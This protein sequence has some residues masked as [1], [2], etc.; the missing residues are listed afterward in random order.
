MKIFNETYLK[1]NKKR[2]IVFIT[3]CSSIV[4]AAAGLLVLFVLLTTDTN[5]ILF[6]ILSCFV[7][8]ISGSSILFI[9]LEFTR[10]IYKNL[11]FYKYVASSKPVILKGII[12]GGGKRITL[13]KGIKAIEYELLAEEKRVVVYFNKEISDYSFS[14]DDKGT[15]TILN[16]FIISYEKEE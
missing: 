10:Q 6:L 9:I 11:Y 4:L 13:Q 1:D 16:N 14:V 8:V 5:Y 12:V 3:I 7:V 15:F 2:L